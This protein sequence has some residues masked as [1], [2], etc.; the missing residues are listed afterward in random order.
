M[1]VFHYDMQKGMGKK[2]LAKFR[3]K[4]NNYVRSYSFLSQIITFVDA[5]LEKFYLFTKLLFK[6][7]PYEKE[8]LPLEVTEMVDMDKYAMQELE[9]GSIL[10]NKEDKTLENTQR[11]GHGSKKGKYE[12]LELIVTEINEQFGYDFKNFHKVMNDV[13]DYLKKDEALKATMRAKDIGDVKKLKFEEVLQSAFIDNIDNV[14][15]IMT[16]MDEDKAF[17][18]HLRNSL[19]EWFKNELE[20]DE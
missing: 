10:L 17:S 7:L 5:D 1:M 3:K 8:T 19:F 20:K 6:Y 11:D 13:K 14:M 4:V 9:N 18:K 12:T 2:L 15:E 16:K